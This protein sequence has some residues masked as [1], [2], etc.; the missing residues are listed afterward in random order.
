MSVC[1]CLPLLQDY[2]AKNEI[3]F[4]LETSGCVTLLGFLSFTAGGIPKYLL[5]LY[6]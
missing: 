2:N 5:S 3:N 1:V 4:P 6:Y